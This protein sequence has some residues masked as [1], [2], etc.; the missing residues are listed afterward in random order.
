MCWGLPAA[1]MHPVFRLCKRL[2]Q[3]Q[4]HAQL[5]TPIPFNLVVFGCSCTL[6]PDV[7]DGSPE[8]FARARAI[9]NE[10]FAYGAYLY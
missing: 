5:T 9:P 8:N 4:P 6:W 10:T 1:L 2:V 3:G 7:E